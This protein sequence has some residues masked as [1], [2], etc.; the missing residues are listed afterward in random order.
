MRFLTDNPAAEP[1]SVLY[2]RCTMD[3][4]SGDMEMAEVPCRNLEDVLGGFGRSLQLLAER[5]IREAYVDENPLIVNVGLL[6][7]SHTMTGMR[8]YFSGYSPIKGF[9]KRIAGRNVVSW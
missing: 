8:T 9:K 7:G 4:K 3:L 6:T 5:E 1:T 2:R